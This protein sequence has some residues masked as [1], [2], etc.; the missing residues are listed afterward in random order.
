M[1]PFCYLGKRKFEN[2]LEQFPEK[3]H[4]EVVWKSFQLNPN[5]ETNTEISIYEY[6]ANIKGF[7]IEQAKRLNDQLTNSAKQVGLEYNFDK[8]VV[9]NTFNAH[10]LLH[11][12]KELGKQNE[13]KERILKAY[14]T[15]GVNVDD[16]PS[17]IRL[18]NEI[19]ID[20]PDL[21]S[22]F[23]NEDLINAANNDIYEAQHLGIHGVPFFVF[24]R[25]YAVSGAQ[26]TEV[27]L[28]T[29]EKSIADWRIEN[30][31]AKFE[32]IIGDTCNIDGIC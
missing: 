19:G 24:N 1:C 32:T 13:A 20:T 15:D 29:L 30:P 5:L 10:I 12:A 2:A 23:E 4:I 17:L 26:E 27:F 21:V 11:Y 8:S 22:I 18:A 9:A 16:I 7:P 28:R 3:D 14:F 31:V 25:K 6:L